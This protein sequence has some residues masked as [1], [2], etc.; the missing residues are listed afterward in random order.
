MGVDENL[1]IQISDTFQYL[2]MGKATSM[3]IAFIALLQLV[4]VQS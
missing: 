2:T 1:I 4:T 3:L